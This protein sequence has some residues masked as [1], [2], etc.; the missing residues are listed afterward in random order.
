VTD[1]WP[2]G[3]STI[4]PVDPSWGSAIASFLLDLARTGDDRWFHPFTLDDASAVRIAA[5]AGA[6]VYLIAT[7][8]DRVVALGMLRGWDEGYAIPSLGIAVAATARGRGLGRA[9]M[10]QLQA[11]AR[12]RGA[13]KVRLTVDTG[14]RAAIELYGSLGYAF[15]AEADGRLVGFLD[16]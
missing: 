2:D 9:M 13:S 11:E 1:A 6:D 15:E 8:K 5:S 14:N 4:R 7:D 12:R 16:L 3:G 10:E